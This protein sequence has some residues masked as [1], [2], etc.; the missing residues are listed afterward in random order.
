ME[1]DSK[2]RPLYV[3][4]LLYEATDDN[5][6]LTT[7][8]IVLLLE[9]KY[10]VKTQRL[11]IPKDVELLE[12]FGYEIG[13]I[14]GQSVSY[15]FDHR[16]F[17]LPELKL[18]IDAVESSSFITEKKERRAYSKADLAGQSVQSIYARKDF[19]SWRQSKAR[20]RTDLLHH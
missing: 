15:Y 18:L 13:R 2:L 8:E 1:H 14:R 12:Q 17:E 16:L 11:Q 9:E 4:K 10:G 3:L 7:S 19:R 6:P 5:H 20:K